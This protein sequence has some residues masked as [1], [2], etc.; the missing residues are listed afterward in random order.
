MEIAFVTRMT[1]EERESFLAEVRVAVVAIPRNDLGPL[2]TPVWYWYEPGGNLWFET[3][4]TSRKGQLMQIGTRISLCVQ[5][6]RPPYTYV[7]VEGPIVE[8]AEDDR[9]LH[10]IPMAIRYMG[11][12][13]G[14]NYITGLPPSEW[15]RYIMHPERWLTMDGSKS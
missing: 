3:Q 14:P 12:E 5:D 9:D 4:P 13:D 8:I 11:K 10:E 1:E 2:T 6:E 15:K 7:S